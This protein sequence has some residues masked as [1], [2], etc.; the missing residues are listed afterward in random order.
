M[1]DEDAGERVTRMQDVV[2]ALL[3]KS[4]DAATAMDATAATTEATF[5]VP[6]AADAEEEEPST[7]AA[8]LGAATLQPSPARLGRSLVRPAGGRRGP[9]HG[10]YDEVTKSPT[11]ARG[12]GAGGVC[13]GV[14]ARGGDRGSRGSAHTPPSRSRRS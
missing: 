3:A 4:H 7:A 9:I 5:H 8:A 14:A 13:S 12:A 6:V 11:K 1:D 2:D 10:P